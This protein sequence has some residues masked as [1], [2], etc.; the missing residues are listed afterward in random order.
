MKHLSTVTLFTLLAVGSM[1]IAS[2]SFMADTFLQ[3]AATP[4]QT[5]ANASRVAAECQT[6]E[7]MGLYNVDMRPMAP[8]IVYQAK[9]RNDSQVARIVTL[10]WLDMYGQALQTTAQVAGGQIATLELSRNSPSD[11]R[12]IE[13]HLA[14][15]Q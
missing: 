4:E 11:R 13:L 7:L 1:S 6:I 15:C 9:V 12:P 2:C 3:P 10:Q 5:Q 14:S 8:L